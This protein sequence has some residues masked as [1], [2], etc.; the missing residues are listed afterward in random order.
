MALSLAVLL[1]ACRANVPRQADPSTPAAAV[2]LL[3]ALATNPATPE[4]TE[5]GLRNRLRKR[6]ERHRRLF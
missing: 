6:F 4:Q 2:K 1:A 5:A 3:V